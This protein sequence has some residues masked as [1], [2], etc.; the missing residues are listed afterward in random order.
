MSEPLQIVLMGEVPVQMF[1]D[2][3]KVAKKYIHNAMAL[4]SQHP[5]SRE[6]GATMVICERADVQEK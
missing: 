3:A 5:I 2:L 4:D 6:H 1:V